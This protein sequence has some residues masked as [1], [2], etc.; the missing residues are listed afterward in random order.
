MQASEGAW[1]VRR[2]LSAVVLRYGE[3]ALR[4]VY[5]WGLFG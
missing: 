1:A 2:V 3:E 4:T 5:L